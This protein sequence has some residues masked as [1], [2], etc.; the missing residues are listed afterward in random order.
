LYSFH[1]AHSVHHNMLQYLHRELSLSITLIPKWRQEVRRIIY[2]FVPANA[3]ID[4]LA[5]H[6]VSNHTI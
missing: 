4:R 1:C 5:G 6:I 3:Y 2:V